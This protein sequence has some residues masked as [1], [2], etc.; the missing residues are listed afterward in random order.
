MARPGKK[1]WSGTLFERGVEA[2]TVEEP[3]KEIKRP[4]WARVHY[5]NQAGEVVH[6]VAGPLTAKGFED[7]QGL[8]YRAEYAGDIAV[9]AVDDLAGGSTRASS[10]LVVFPSQFTGTPF[11]REEVEAEPE[12][13]APPSAPEPAKSLQEEAAEVRQSLFA[14]SSKSEKVH[15]SSIGWIEI[16]G[17]RYW[18]AAVV[19]T[20]IDKV[21]LEED[22]AGALEKELARSREIIQSLRNDLFGRIDQCEALEKSLE[23]TAGECDQARQD[24]EDTRRELA[25]ERM[26]LAEIAR[27]AARGSV[28]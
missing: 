21:K 20:W 14:E 22:R 17:Q 8:Q 4:K 25:D 7:L 23:K 26:L 1:P 2:L 11:Q 5:K 3:E 27:V 13:V 15:R 16:E 24:L 10:R 12:P 28:K 19:E 18:P 6:C 9:L